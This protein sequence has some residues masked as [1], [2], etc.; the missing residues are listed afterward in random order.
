MPGFV[1]VSNMTS[2]EVRRMGHADDYDEPSTWRPRKA[3][4]ARNNLVPQVGFPVSDVWAAACAAQ[5]V[6][7]EYL[8]EGRNTY[9]DNGEVLSTTR[10]NRD[11]M[12]EFLHNPSNLTVDDVEAGEAVRKWLQN[13]LT[14]RALKSQLTEFDSA[15]QKCLAVTDRFYTVSQRYELAVV[16][17]LPNVYAKAKAREV[18]Q[19]RLRET[20]GELIGNVGDKVQ[21]NVEVIRTV[22]SKTWGCWFLTAVTENNQAVFFSNKLGILSGTKLLIKG[23]VKAHKDGQTQ[24]NRVSVL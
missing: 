10:R 24:L 14:F 3:A 9:G 4:S 20:S 18:T 15:T 17:A 6:N 7:G 12:V 1:D 16:A 2:E 8:K 19:D 13:D 23:T 11:I 22:F 21:L 5:R